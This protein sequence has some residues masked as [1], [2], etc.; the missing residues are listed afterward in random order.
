MVS[1]PFNGAIKKQLRMKV[2]GTT[3]Q[4]KFQSP[5]TGQLKSNVNLF[6]YS[7]RQKRVSVPFNGAIKKQHNIDDNFNLGV[8]VSVP[9]NGAIKKQQTGL[10]VVCK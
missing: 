6:A 5:S 4:R 8:Y 9:F 3:T 7:P 10:T 2:A 1:V